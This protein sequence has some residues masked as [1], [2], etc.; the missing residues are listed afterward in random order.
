MRSSS[1]PLIRWRVPVPNC[2]GRYTRPSRMP[3][4]RQGSPRSGGVRLVRS[5]SGEQKR[6]LLC[7]TDTDPEDIVS[8][9]F[10][11]VGSAQR[12]RGGAVLQHG[13]LLLARSCR[14]PELLGICDVADESARTHNWSNRL[15]DCIPAALGLDALTSRCRS[16]S[17]SAPW[18]WSVL[19]I[20]TPRG[21]GSVNR[22]QRRGSVV[23]SMQQQDHGSVHSGHKKSGSC[24]F[25]KEPILQGEVSSLDLRQIELEYMGSINEDDVT[26]PLRPY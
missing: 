10:K 5:G 3:C 6:P 20:K 12:R 19:V 15:L 23:T 26:S 8:G 22:V 14:T 7:F 2:I 18:N 16:R 13:S 24:E 11:I 21:P 9:D 17:G 25:A 1:R 4:A